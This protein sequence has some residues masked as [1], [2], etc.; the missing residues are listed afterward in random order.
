MP[1]ILRDLPFGPDPNPRPLLVPGGRSI[2]FRR[3]RIVVWV[4][5]TGLD[6]SNLPV[7][8]PRFPAVLDTGFNDSF[9]ISALQLIRWGPSGIHT[10]I[11]RNGLA[12]SY[13]GARLELY[14]ATV[15]IHP[16]IPGRIEPDLGERP[17]Q[18]SLPNGIAVAPAGTPA[19]RELPLI[20]LMAIRFSDLRVEID[21]TR[22]CVSV[23]APD[24]S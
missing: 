12:L 1:R 22:E 6:S 2:P 14:D 16:N 7:D 15:W 21:G 4:S 24:R 3:D 11:F 9:L 5:V 8:A 23:S 10:D 17:F 20:G 19:E 13:A 18:L